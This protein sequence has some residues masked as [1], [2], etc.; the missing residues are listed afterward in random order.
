MAVVQNNKTNS[1]SLKVV[2][3]VD[4]GGGKTYAKRNFNNN[5]NV[6]ATD[7]DCRDVGVSIAGLQEHQLDS[8]RRTI[9]YDIAA[10]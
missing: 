6:E 7:Q 10:E 5:V 2:T 8:V 4:A 9:A 3:A 1:L